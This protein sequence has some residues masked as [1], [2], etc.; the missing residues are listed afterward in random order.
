[1][2]SGIVEEIGT[3]S[4]SATTSAGLT[5]TFSCST[6]LD[7]TRIGD[8]IAVDGVCLT[9]AAMDVTGFTANLQPVTARLSTL[10]ELRPG[11]RVNLERAVAAG[12]RMGG[13]YVQGHVDGSGQIV[14]RRGE[15]AALI[16]EIEIPDATRR[17]VVE[18][19]FVAVDGASLTIMSRT[20]SAIAVSLVY[21]TQQNITLSTKRPGDRVNLEAD[22]IAR[23]VESLVAPYGND[24]G[25]S[26]ETLRKAGFV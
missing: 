6:V 3:V 9:V 21:H 14:T 10:G 18:R 16:V 11:A 8:S 13:H 19:G 25:I 5:L 24:A 20:D 12:Q 23:Y 2:F 17:Y 1:M 26:M 7:E 15:G 22:V 4:R